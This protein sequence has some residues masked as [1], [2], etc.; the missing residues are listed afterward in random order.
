[1]QYAVLRRPGNEKNRVPNFLYIDEFPDFICNNTLPLFTMYRK[2]RVGTIISAQNIGQLNVTETSKQTILANCTTKFVFGNN[3]PADNE[4][5]AQELGYKKM[6]LMST[7]VHVGGPGDVKQSDLK[8]A[9]WD[10]TLNFKPMAIQSFKFKVC[11][12]KTKDPGGKFYAA[13]ITLNFMDS[14]YKEPHSSKTFDFSKFN[15]ATKVHS[16]NHSDSDSYGLKGFNDYSSDEEV[17]PI[18]STS[19]FLFNNNDAIVF[20]INKKNNTN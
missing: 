17:N 20:D 1:M 14:E 2:Y 8:G 9:K 4:W 7:D 12:F 3:S 11:G 15:S 10:W 13:K 16:G 5:W 19:S 6:W 18:Q